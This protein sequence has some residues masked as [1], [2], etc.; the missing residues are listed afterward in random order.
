MNYDR[1]LPEGYVC[2]GV[3]FKGTGQYERGPWSRA[4]YGKIA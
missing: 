2:L 4:V 3:V 1:Y